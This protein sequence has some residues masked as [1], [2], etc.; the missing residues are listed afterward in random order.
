MSGP[1]KLRFVEVRVS[2]SCCLEMIPCSVYRKLI[3]LYCIILVSLKKQVMQE[4]KVEAH[5][6]GV[7][8]FYPSV[9]VLLAPTTSLSRLLHFKVFLL[10]I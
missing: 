1:E 9:V 6:L 8:L 5:I 7:F 3:Q 10:G 4:A 2:F